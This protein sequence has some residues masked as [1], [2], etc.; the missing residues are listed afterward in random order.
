[1]TSQQLLAIVAGTGA[2]NT[3]SL[4][5]TGAAADEAYT[6]AVD[7]LTRLGVTVT[8]HDR[9][10]TGSESPYE[11]AYCGGEGT[12]DDYLLCLISPLGYERPATPTERLAVAPITQ[13]DLITVTPEGRRA[14]SLV[15]G[16]A[17]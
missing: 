4:N 1:M 14:L 6:A 9:T 10:L 15:P 12:S 2:P 3:A 13:D 11:V 16:G 17:A 5:Y 7:A 8:R